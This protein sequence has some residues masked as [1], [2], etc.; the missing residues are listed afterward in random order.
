MPDAKSRA[1]VERLLRGP[2]RPD[3]LTGLFLFA[4]D[5][6]D[7]REAVTDIGDFV[8]HHAERTKGIVT[9]LTREWFAAAQ[10]HMAL[11]RP[12]GPRTL[13]PSRLPAAAQDYFKI[14][15]KR[16]DQKLLSEKTG[17]SRIKAHDMM[18]SLAGRM[19]PNP[20]GTWQFPTNHT[21]QEASLLVCVS[22]T[23]VIK[24]A[25][26]DETL[27]REFMDTLKSNGLISKQ[28]IREHGDD[29][30]ALV[31]LYAVSVMHNCVIKIDDT[32]DTKLIANAA[33]ADRKI[34]V[35][36][37]VRLIVPGLNRVNINTA[38]F[39]ANLDPELHCHSDL[40]EAEIWDFEIEVGADGRLCKFA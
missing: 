28:E 30:A 3:D 13:D 32:T 6:C 11:Y 14:A 9:R 31:R 4:R 12:P 27:V 35:S 36:Y 24:S 22:E 7:G 18:I 37:I 33:V 39:I 40:L 26:E 17:L 38:I 23:I 20:D 5:H 8:A 10:F 29:V 19:N 2:F 21:P 16:L 25:F 34:N 15:A 1:R